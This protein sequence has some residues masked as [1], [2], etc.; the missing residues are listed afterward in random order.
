MAD[1][2]K[3][4][5]V[6]QETAKAREARLIE[7]YDIRS[8]GHGKWVLG[9]DPFTY[10]NKTEVLKAAAAREVEDTI[11]DD[12]KDVVPKGYEPEMFSMRDRSVVRNSVMELPMNEMYDPDGAKNPHYDREFVWS[13]GYLERQAIAMA[14]AKG[15]E[16]V[17][18]KEFKDS[19]KH[20]RIPAALE[21]LV[22]DDGNRMVHGDSV[23]LRAPR[24]LWRQRRAEK[25]RESEKVLGDMHLQEM[26]SMP[27][28]IRGTQ[29]TQN[30][31]KEYGLGS[32]VALLEA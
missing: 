32:E 30:V 22:Y 12:L 20:G 19:V 16:E 13:W 23:L 2:P 28:D 7:T 1:K 15:Y 25:W 29:L 18:P 5:A 26:G 4:D 21:S 14:R 27:R 17:T 24:Y 3:Q 31:I 9:E 11:D 10:P 8:V 6:K